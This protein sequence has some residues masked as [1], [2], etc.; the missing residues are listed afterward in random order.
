MEAKLEMDIVHAL[1]GRTRFLVPR[2]GEHV[3]PAPPPDPREASPLLGNY[4]NW[5]VLENCRPI[6]RSGRLFMRTKI[7]GEMRH[8][9]FVLTGGHLLRFHL[10]KSRTALHSHAKTINLLDAFVT[11][12]Y[13]AALEVDHGDNSGVPSGRRFQDGLETND[14]DKDTLIIIR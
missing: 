4:W 12:G 9:Y 14:S 7:H 2:V 11:S 13:F 5:C 6:T 1:S 8:F 3:Y 10:S